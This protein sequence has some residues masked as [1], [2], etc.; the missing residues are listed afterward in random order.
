MPAAGPLPPDG[1]WLVTALM[2]KVAFWPL[3]MPWP[4]V[5]RVGPSPRAAF[6]SDSKQIVACGNTGTSVYPLTP[7]AP[8]AHPLAGGRVSTCYGLAMESSGRHVLLAATGYGPVLAPLD[9]GEAQALVRTSPRESISAVALDAK[10]R[11]AATAAY[12]RPR[13]RTGCCTSS[14]AGRA[15]RRALPLPGAEGEDAYSGGVVALRFV[16][17]ERLLT[18]GVAGLRRW[19]PV[20]GGNEVLHPSPCGPMDASAD[21]RRVAVGCD[22]PGRGV[23]S[24]GANAAYPGPPFELLAIDTSTGE[25]RT[26]ETHGRDFAS[27]AV[28]P[29]GELLATGDSSGTVRV[30]RI[31]GSEPHLL[32]GAGG[33]VYSLAFSPD[34]R[35][36]ASTAGNDIRLWPMPDLSQP[37]LHTLPHD[38]LLAKLDRLTNVRVVE[39][40]ASPSGYKIDLAPF[41]GWKDVPKW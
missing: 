30:G 19:D 21:G 14:T 27:V 7:D 4:R 9:G 34:G 5:I 16:S 1:R 25:R 6:S 10:G 8:A 38:V 2:T 35:W 12:T 22:E 31:D 24:E 15:R 11:W 39:D 3:E 41:P 23:G 28:S 36:I 17:G 40:K 33:L 18:S 29:S 32:V 37:P 13:S 26:I 20:T